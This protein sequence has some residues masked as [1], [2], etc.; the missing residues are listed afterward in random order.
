M[1]YIGA[2][3]RGFDHKAK[4]N[5]WMM[6][7]GIAFRDMGAFEYNHEDDY[8]DWAVVVCEEV[9]RDPGKHRG[10]LICGSGVGVSVAANKVAKIR[11]GLGF[12]PDQTHAARKDDDINVLAIAYDNTATEKAILV[13]EQFLVTEFVERERHVRRREK[14]ERMERWERN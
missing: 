1:I 9:A 4:I 8:V 13:V 6:G 12:E 5:E 11:C 14:I 2:D 10:V 7:R 3:H